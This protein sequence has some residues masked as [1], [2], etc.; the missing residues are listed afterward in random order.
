MPLGVCPEGGGRGV[1]WLIVDLITLVSE[2]LGKSP[3]VWYR[4]GLRE[5]E[6]VRRVEVY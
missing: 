1:D 3:V 6:D 2:D 4:G 5:E